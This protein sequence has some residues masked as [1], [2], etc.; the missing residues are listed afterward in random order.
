MVMDMIMYGDEWWWLV[1]NGYDGWWWMIMM[2]GD[3]WLWWVVMI[4]GDGHDYVWWWTVMEMMDGDE[5]WWCW[6]MM[7]IVMNYGDGDDGCWWMMVKQK[8][9]KFCLAAAHSNH[10]AFGAKCFCSSHG[11][12]I[13]FAVVAV[14]GCFCSYWRRYTPARAF[15]K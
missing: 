10:C 15:S 14:T 4:D 5:W 3:E 9:R 12:L 7:M 11:S 6:I 13:A 8:V 1:M 2:G